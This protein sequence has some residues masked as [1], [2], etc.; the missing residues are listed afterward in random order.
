L[1]PQIDHI[2]ITVQDLDRAEAFYDLF[3]PLLGFDPE[4]KVRVAI[5]EHDFEVIEYTHENLAF[6][7]TSP[8]K[9]FKDDPVHRRRPGALHHLAFSAGSREEIDNLYRALL[10]IKANVVD[11]PRIFPE[12]GP[13]YYAVYFKDCENIKYEFVYREA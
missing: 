13:S 7:L 2:Q 1:I 5:P 12:Y 11:G 10:R 9:A 6:A 4:K 8:R 3:L